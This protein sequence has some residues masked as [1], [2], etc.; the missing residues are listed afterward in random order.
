M[1]GQYIVGAWRIGTV[2]DNAASRAGAPSMGVTTQ[3]KTWR[4]IHAKADLSSSD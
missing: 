4:W 2:L 3:S 1:T